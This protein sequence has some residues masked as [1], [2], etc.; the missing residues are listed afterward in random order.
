MFVVF[1]AASFIKSAEGLSEF[2]EVGANEVGGFFA[3]GV[4]QDFSI[5]DE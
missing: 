3:D 2:E 1:D 4:A 5:I